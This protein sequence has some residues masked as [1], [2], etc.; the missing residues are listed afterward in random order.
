LNDLTLHTS[1][2]RSVLIFTLL[3]LLDSLGNERYALR[4]DWENLFSYF[5][6]I[7]H[8]LDEVL[9]LV[10]L[11]EDCPQLRVHCLVVIPFLHDTFND[12]LFAFLP[13]LLFV[14]DLVHNYLL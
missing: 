6:R 12:G 8:F 4:V 5:I 1:P 7:I 13:V 11:Y 2:Y 3:F 10:Q 9:F 14:V